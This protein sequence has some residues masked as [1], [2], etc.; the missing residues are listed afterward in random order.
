VTVLSRLMPLGIATSISV[1]VTVMFM[2][3]GPIE[4][5]QPLL[6]KVHDA[7]RLAHNSVRQLLPQDGFADAR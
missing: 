2:T 5:V 4:R 7:I 1:A 3:P 6:P